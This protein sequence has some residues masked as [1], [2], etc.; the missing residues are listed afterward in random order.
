[1]ARSGNE[2]AEMDRTQAVLVGLL[3]AMGKEVYR[4][5]LVKLAYLMD[6]AYYR[7]RG[8]TLT[9]L[10]Y[11]WDHYG[12]NATD[13]AIP[14]CLDEIV[15]S[16][17]ITMIERRTPYN[18]SAY[19]YSVSPDCDPADLPLSGDDW[20]EI[21]TVVHNYGSMN[22]DQIVRASKATA[23][24]RGAT[25]YEKLVFTQD[26]PLTP[27]EIAADP[28]WRETFAAMHDTSERISIDELRARVAQSSEP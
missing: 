19:A 27:E 7:I 5:K 13:N 22:R 11:T 12:P 8:Q 14:R 9:G 26:P 24:M 4:T 1:M 17:A 2:N 23:P 16:G 6:E 21:H 10:D 20:I 3:Y 18:N 25:Q 15:E 28:F